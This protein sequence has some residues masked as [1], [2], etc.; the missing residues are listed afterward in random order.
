M[1][2]LACACRLAGSAE[3]SR[4]HRLIRARNPSDGRGFRSVHARQPLQDSGRTSNSGGSG[5]ET[6]CRSATGI[7]DPHAGVG[8]GG[9]RNYKGTRPDGNR[10]HG[11]GPMPTVEF[12]QNRNDLLHRESLALN[13]VFSLPVLPGEGHMDPRSVH[14]CVPVRREERLFVETIAGA[15]SKVS[16]RE[17]AMPR[18]EKGS[19]ANGLTVHSWR[20]HS[21]RPS[22]GNAPPA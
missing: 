7:A 18:Q 17:S 8:V 11:S 1:A 15:R 6:V 9:S 10:Q 21:I 20:D 4:S 13:G 12:P 5:I 19:S 14:E 3:N 22:P 2:P 16:E